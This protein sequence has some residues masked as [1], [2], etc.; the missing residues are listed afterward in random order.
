MTA[1]LDSALKRELDI[2]GE[3]YTLT[4]TPRG[5]KLTPKGKRLGY[6]LQWADLVSGDAA[7]ATELRASLAH[8]PPPTHVPPPAPPRAARAA[9][10][11]P[12]TRR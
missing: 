3:L 1:R 10:A 9:R 2:E 4:L 8:V 12:R 6:E 11:K 5:F 7:L